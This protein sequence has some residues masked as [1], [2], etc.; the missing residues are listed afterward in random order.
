M[1]THT[2]TQCCFKRGG[3]EGTLL[4]VVLLSGSIG[5]LD[6]L[7]CSRLALHNV[8]IIL[9]YPGSLHHPTTH[10]PVLS[11]GKYYIEKNKQSLWR[12]KETL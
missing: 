3:S 1:H 12:P 4:S 10:D 5:P 7:I 9:H 2:H 8:N 6:Y 11:Y